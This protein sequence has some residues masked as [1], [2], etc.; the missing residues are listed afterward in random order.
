MMWLLPE[1]R[2]RNNPQVM[3]MRKMFRTTVTSSRPISPD[4]R[5][6]TSHERVV[7]SFGFL[8]DMSSDDNVAEVDP[9]SNSDDEEPNEAR[10]PAV[11][12]TKQQ[13]LE[14]PYRVQCKQRQEKRH[15][16]LEQA[17]HDIEKLLLSAKTRFSGGQNGLQACRACAIQSHLRL[18]TKQQRGFV[19]AAERAAESHGFAVKWGG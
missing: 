19:D 1:P 8:S 6:N 18:V 16:E 7:A 13:R 2:C 12:H 11:P 5:T 4:V 17:F 15:E 9:V 3:L 14:V 10:L